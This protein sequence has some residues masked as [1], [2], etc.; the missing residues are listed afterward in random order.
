MKIG[1]IYEANVLILRP[2]CNFTFLE[3]ALLN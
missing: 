2:Y 1:A 3:I